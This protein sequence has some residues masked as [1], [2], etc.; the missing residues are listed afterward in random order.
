MKNFSIASL[1]WLTVVIALLTSLGLSYR[2]LAKEKASAKEAL[3]KAEI[4]KEAT[5]AQAIDELNLN[6][7]NAFGTA[8]KYKRRMGYF[9]NQVLPAGMS[10]LKLYN[11]PPEFGG[12]MS[13]PAPF[14]WYWRIHVAEPEKFRLSFAG[15][16]IPKSGFEV[17]PEFV[18][19]M[20]IDPAEPDFDGVAHSGPTGKIAGFDMKRPIEIIMI[21]TVKPSAEGGELLVRW[22]LSQ[23]D[24]GVIANRASGIKL[25]KSDMSWFYSELSPHQTDWRLDGYGSLEQEYENNQAVFDMS[26]PQLLMRIRGK[27]PTDQKFRFA[28]YKGPTNGV[29]IW[30]PAAGDFSVDK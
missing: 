16:G 12:K 25:S 8:A 18:K 11:L 21:A 19:T 15:L 22:N 6:I 30:I 5:I 1:L 29:M 2:Q 9:D 27:N 13:R 26:E 14:H 4:E 10:R 23:Q 28:P 3:A 20:R 24:T 17:A 7:R